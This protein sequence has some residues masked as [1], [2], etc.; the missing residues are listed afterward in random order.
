M[1]QPFM[2]NVSVEM[3]MVHRIDSTTTSLVFLFSFL[4]ALY[5]VL[6]WS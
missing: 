1:L 3:E 5:L 4:Y 2:R 6:D